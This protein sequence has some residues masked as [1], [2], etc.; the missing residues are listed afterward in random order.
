MARAV[1]PAPRSR[2]GEPASSEISE[3]VAQALEGGQRI[4]AA[5][6]DRTL[7]TKSKFRLLPPADLEEALG[8]IGE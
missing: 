2:T 8:G 7:P 4:E 1:P 5:V 3:T 6:L